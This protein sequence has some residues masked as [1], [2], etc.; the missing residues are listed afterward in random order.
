MGWSYNLSNK[1]DCF[2][3]WKVGWGVSFSYAVARCNLE[4]DLGKLR[5]MIIPVFRF[6]IKFSWTVQ[7]S[8]WLVLYYQHC[9][10]WFPNGTWVGRIWWCPEH[11]SM[12]RWYCITII[13]L[14]ISAP[15]VCYVTL[16]LWCL[17]YCTCSIN[18]YWI[19]NQMPWS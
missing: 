9:I 14:Y 12:M 7:Y 17:T 3:E 6:L 8:Q 18:V 13:F 19:Y 11:I 5:W 10:W 1:W 15:M 16:H 4:T 2:W